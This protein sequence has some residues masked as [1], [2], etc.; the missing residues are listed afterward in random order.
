MSTSLVLLLAS[1]FIASSIEGIEVMVIVLGVGATRGW[2]ATLIGVAAGLVVLAAVVGILG[3]ALTGI[4]I[5]SMRVVVGTLLLI[6]GMK[7]LVKGVYRIGQAG[8][9]NAISKRASGQPGRRDS[10]GPRRRGGFDWTAF[11]IALKGV[12]LEGLE[13]AFIVVT[14][15]VEAGQ[16]LWAS[17][18]ALAAIAII[19]GLAVLARGWVESIP[20]P[21]LRWGVGVMLVTFGTFW[22]SEGIGVGWPFGDGAIL[23]LLAVYA[24]VSLAYVWLIRGHSFPGVETRSQ[25]ELTGS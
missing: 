7:W 22:A 2:R 14:F 12:V 10:G 16:L 18:A 15:G 3:T 11:V 19:A 4:P 23:G 17:I 20:R 5:A 13:V 21:W 9:L 8:S 6:F 25:G 1:T 24:L